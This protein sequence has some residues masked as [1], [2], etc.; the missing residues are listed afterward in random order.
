M[1]ISAFRGVKLRGGVKLRERRK[2][3]MYPSALNK[4]LLTIFIVPLT[5]I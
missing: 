2:T 5:K 1:P 3:I 4:M